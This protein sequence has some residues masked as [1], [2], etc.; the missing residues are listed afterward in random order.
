MTFKE[1]KLLTAYIF[2][3][4]KF[5]EAKF[6]L[7]IGFDIQ[8]TKFITCFFVPL[9]LTYFNLVQN[10]FVLLLLLKIAF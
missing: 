6:V 9:V 2:F 8:L 7:N 3:V 1:K 4:V 5:F 10:N